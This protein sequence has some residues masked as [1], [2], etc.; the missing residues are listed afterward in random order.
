MI[1][2]KL[3]K[4]TFIAY[5]CGHYPIYLDSMKK[6]AVLAFLFPAFAPFNGQ[7][8]YAQRIQTYQQVYS[9]QDTNEKELKMMSSSKKLVID[10]FGAIIRGDTLKKHIAL[11]FTGD[12]FADGGMNILRTLKA[13]KVKSSFFLTGR[14]YSTPEFRPLITQLKAQGHYFGAHSDQHLLYCDWVKRDSLLVT[15]EQFIEDLNNNYTLMQK[16]GIQKA[17]AP[18]FLPPY[19]WY[20]STIVNWTAEES[21]QLVNFSP[22][23]RST[24]DYTWPELGKSY[25]PSDEIYH[26]IIDREEKDPNGLNGFILLI[27][28]GTD[29]RRTDKF[30][31][32]LPE[33]LQELKK[34]GYKFERID[35]MLN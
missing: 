2:L 25:R 10:Q 8:L 23:T 17:D 4:I 29:P 18:Y 27:H 3:D 31:F 28:I 9:A 13:E 15:R 33:L 22:G 14:F 1:N 26:S 5:G 12:E 21:L 6:I 7:Q 11:V 34:R 20:N 35:E 16:F 32:R 24:A 19:E 30:Y